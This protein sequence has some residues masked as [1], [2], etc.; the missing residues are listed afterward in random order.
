MATINVFLVAVAIFLGLVVQQGDS[1]F[2]QLRHP[3]QHYCA[4]DYGKN[5]SLYFGGTEGHHA[6]SSN[7]ICSCK[8][9]F[10]ALIYDVPNLANVVLIVNTDTKII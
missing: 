3:Q 2:C 5:A 7:E 8:Y 9:T 10:F 1:C 6:R 4:S